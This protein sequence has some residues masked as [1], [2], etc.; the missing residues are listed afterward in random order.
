[1]RSCKGLERVVDT[2]GL[3]C[4]GREV[5][6]GDSLSELQAVVG[7]PA[8]HIW[9]VILILLGYLFTALAFAL[10]FVFCIFNQGYHI[11][12]RT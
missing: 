5:S 8:S 4:I 2:G 6:R 1:V 7:Q 11:H 9:R 12:N 10:S 3:F